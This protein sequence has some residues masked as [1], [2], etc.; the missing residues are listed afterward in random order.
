M[1]KKNEVAE[2]I[3]KQRSYDLNSSSSESNSND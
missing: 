1:S 2:H 3:M